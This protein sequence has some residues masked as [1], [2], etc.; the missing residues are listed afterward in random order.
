MLEEVSPAFFFQL[1][2][3]SRKGRTGFSSLF[4]SKFLAKEVNSRGLLVFSYPLTLEFL[5]SHERT[6]LKLIIRPT[7]VI[8]VDVKIVPLELVPKFSD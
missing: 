8:V 3:F 5:D 2:S 6:D 4:T 7:E 1:Y